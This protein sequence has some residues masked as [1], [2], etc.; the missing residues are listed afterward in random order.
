MSFSAAGLRE[1][2]REVE[3]DGREGQGPL[4]SLPQGDTLRR[5]MESEVER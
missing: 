2:R 1:G 4:E 5:E 3:E